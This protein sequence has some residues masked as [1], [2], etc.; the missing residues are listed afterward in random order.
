MLTNRERSARAL[1]DSPAYPP[2][3]DS[4]DFVDEPETDD[5]QDEDGEE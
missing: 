1:R 4:R 5:E 3:V 2:G